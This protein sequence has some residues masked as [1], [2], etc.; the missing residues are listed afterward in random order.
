MAKWLNDLDTLFFQLWNRLWWHKR[1]PALQGWIQ[2]W[3][4]GTWWCCDSRKVHIWAAE[5]RQEY[6][7]GGRHEVGWG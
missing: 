1:V 3:E 2:N 5:L 7:L 4:R 6:L